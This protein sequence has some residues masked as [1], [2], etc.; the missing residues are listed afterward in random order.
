MTG[1]DRFLEAAETGVE[2]LR[3][4]LRNVDTSE[5][6]A[7]WYHAIEINEPSEKKILASEFG[8]DYE[9]I[10][11]YE[12]IYALAGP[13]QTFRITGDPRIKERHRRDDLAVRAVLLRPRARRL[14]LAPR[15]DHVRRARATSLGRNRARKNWNSVGDHAPAYLINA[16]AGDRRRRSTPTCSSYDRR[17]HRG[18]LPGLRQQPVRPGAVPRGLEP[19]P[20][21]GAGSRTGR[22]S[23]T[24]SR[25]PGT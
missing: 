9:A 11:A 22:S 19:R 18:A 24:T 13:T 3:E 17:H 20:R 8:D 7:Y 14:L 16:V 4:H 5:G 21:P 12:Q 15:P 1:E 23:A 6:I 10:P 25:S 2:Y